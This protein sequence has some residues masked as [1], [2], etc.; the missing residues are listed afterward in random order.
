MVQTP[1]LDARVGRHAHKQ[2]KHRGR[3]TC[4]DKGVCVLLEQQVLQYAALSHQPKQVMIAA[5]EHVQPASVS[6][7]YRLL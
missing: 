7:T 5:K 3:C 2:R 1:D 6:K 4:V